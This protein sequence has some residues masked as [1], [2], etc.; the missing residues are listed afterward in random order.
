MLAVAVIATPGAA[1]AQRAPAAREIADSARR[2]IEAAQFVGDTLR[3]DAIRGYIGSG[4]KRF[5]NDPL[6]L[7]YAG[8]AAYRRLNLVPDSQASVRIPAMVKDARRLL[9][10]SIKI[11]PMAESYAVLSSLI[12]RQIGY[13]PLQGDVYILEAQAATMAGMNFASENPRV[14]LMNGIAAFYT[15]P[16]HG[17]G[18]PVVEKTLK[19][20]IRFF[21]AE[22]V[23]APMPSW[24]H[25]EAYVWLG[26]AL[27]KQDRI[28][29]ARTA[30]TK[31]LEIEP[32][33][34][35]VTYVLM[36]ELE[37]QSA[38]RKAK[39]Q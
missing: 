36:P 20:S 37:T 24:G 15:A 34:G 8:Y 31:A 5:P 9:E 1:T 10:R 38:N 28:E 23:A 3:L 22:K 35:W 30:Y 29:E 27:A 33:F 4:M 17:G 19:R 26:Q 32:K 12:G 21:E 13:Y 2:E 18:Y 25:A 6:L 11:R 14:W 7:H 16:Q 39:T